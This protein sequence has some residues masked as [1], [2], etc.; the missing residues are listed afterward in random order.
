MYSNRRW[1]SKAIWI[2]L[3]TVA[4]P[5]AATGQVRHI[6][7][8]RNFLT[9]LADEARDVFNTRCNLPTSAAGQVSCRA[10]RPGSLEAR[11]ELRDRCRRKNA[12][13]PRTA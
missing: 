5:Y 8:P 3:S 12:T 7:I 1:I 10:H 9:P 13:M 6:Q 4:L 11:S 2:A